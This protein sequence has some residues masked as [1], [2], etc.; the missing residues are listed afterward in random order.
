MNAVAC[1]HVVFRVPEV[2]LLFCCCVFGL[3]TGSSDMAPFSRDNSDFSQTPSPPPISNGHYLDHSHAL[4]NDDNSDKNDEENG[5]LEHEQEV[6]DADIL[7]K[8]KVCVP[9]LWGL[10]CGLV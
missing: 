7:E 6:P 5:P 9:T 4:N 1:I 2:M 3:Q 8:G 10:L